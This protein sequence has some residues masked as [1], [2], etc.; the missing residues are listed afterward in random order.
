MCYKLTFIDY[1]Q[2]AIAL[3]EMVEYYESVIHLKL[4]YNKNLGL[5]AWAA[6]ARMIRKVSNKWADNSTGL[7]TF[8]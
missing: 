2:S 7:C 5:R 3:F 1:L 4:A 6:A 8:L